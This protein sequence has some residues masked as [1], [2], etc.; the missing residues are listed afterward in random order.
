LPVN[1]LI[2]DI[3]NTLINFNLHL[4]SERFADL[5]DVSEGDIYDFIFK[6]EFFVKFE[7]GDIGPEE[8]VSILNQHFQQDLTVNSFDQVF[9]PIFSPRIQMV[10]L[11]DKLRKEFEL[12]LLSNTNVLHSRYLESQYSFLLQFDYRFYS[13]TLRVLKPNEE[14]YQLVLSRTLSDPRECLFIDD[15]E[16]HVE[17]ARKSGIDAIH[18][19]GEEQLEI[20]L[21][22]RKI[23][24]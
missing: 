9:S 22:K 6:S 5:F 11:I 3:G 2:F 7:K 24:K 12:S 18:F 21:R 1:H 16:M 14:I 17:G 8:L 15:I 13:H 10:N 4:V 23:L 20:E 19:Q